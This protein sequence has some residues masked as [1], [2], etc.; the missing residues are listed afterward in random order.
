MT[1]KLNFTLL[2]CI[3][4]LFNFL[5]NT[6]SVFSFVVLPSFLPFP[7]YS[8]FFF[9]L[10]IHFYIYRISYLFSLNCLFYHSIPVHSIPIYSCCWIFIYFSGFLSLLFFCLFKRIS[11]FKKY[12]HQIILIVH[13]I[14]SSYH[15]T[16]LS[17]IHI[18]IHFQCIYLQPSILS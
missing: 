10:F 12:Y 11:P 7:L 13:S 17:N 1:K 15:P 18:S 2:N 16:L 6:H 9:F 4:N 14:S 3:S 5:R 8:F